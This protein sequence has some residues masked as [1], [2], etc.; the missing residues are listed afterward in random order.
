MRY[1]YAVIGA[2]FCAIRS[3][4][5]LLEAAAVLATFA[6][7]NFKLFG[8]IQYGTTRII[9][10]WAID[11]RAKTYLRRARLHPVRLFFI[12]CCC[13]G[14]FKRKALLFHSYYVLRIYFKWIKHT[15]F[16]RHDF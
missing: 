6:H 9:T 3:I 5:F 7:P 10:D 4:P 13:G 14:R 15:Y 12:H 11:L 1:T 8:Y 2:K 16:H